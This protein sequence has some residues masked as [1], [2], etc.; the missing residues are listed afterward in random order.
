MNKSTMI[1]AIFAASAFSAFA[2]DVYSSNIVGYN[3]LTL[4][5][6]YNLIAPSFVNVG[7]KTRSASRPTMRRGRT[8][9]TAA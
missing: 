1:A 6:G 5:P 2:A 4:N 7:S 3:K 9:P 8:H